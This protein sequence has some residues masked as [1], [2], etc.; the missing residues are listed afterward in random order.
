MPALNNKGTINVSGVIPRTPDSYGPM[1]SFAAYSSALGGQCQGADAFLDTS[2]NVTVFAG[3]KS[4]LFSLTSSSSAPANVS[5][6]SGAYGTP[7][8]G[9]WNFAQFGAR[10]LATNFNDQIQTFTLG[11]SSAFANLSASAPKARYSAVIKSFYVVANTEDSTNGAQPQRVWWPANNDPTNWPTPGTA[12]AAEVQSDFV[13]IVGDGGWNQGIVGNLGT[14]DGALFQEHALWRIVYE[15][16]PATFGF[17]P[18]EGARGTPAPNSIVHF[19]NQV[20]YLGE[21][22]YYRF[23]GTNSFPIGANRVDKTFFSNLNQNFFF[24]IWGTVDPI[25]KLIIWTYPSANSTAGLPDSLLLYNWQIDRWASAPASLETI[26]R[27]LSFGYNLDSLD[28]TGYNLDTLPYS[29]DSRV[30]TGGR[31]LLAGVDQNH[32]IG[33][34]NAASMAATV[35][36]AEIQPFPG[37]RG[38]V[39]RVRPIVDGGTPSVTWGT[40]NRQEDAISFGSAVAMDSNGSCPLRGEGR[41]HRGRI[42]INAGDSWN[43]IEGLQVEEASP[44]GRR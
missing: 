11:T 13:D 21:D 36:T 5:K 6:S 32:K 37:L 28:N 39:N 30:W 23:D 17:Y 3:D 29:L 43:H 42:T 26:F 25:N 9:Q 33:Y 24:N 22:G 15:G 19:S 38:T 35:D 14:S 31:L 20:F 10:V 7:S 44:S 8:D 34:F 4:D 16:P 41:Y 2:G 27:A 40:R 1:P 18:A 12:T